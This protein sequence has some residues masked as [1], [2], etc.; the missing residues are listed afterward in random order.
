MKMP[1]RVTNLVMQILFLTSQKV[2]AI[3]LKIIFRENAL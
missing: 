1:V 3:R 2:F